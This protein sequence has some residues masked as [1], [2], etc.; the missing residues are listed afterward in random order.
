MTSA[1]PLQTSTVSPYSA[2][3]RRPEF[4]G[5]RSVRQTSRTT[6]AQRGETFSEAQRGEG[7]LTAESDA[8]DVEA[9]GS[10]VLVRG[11]G[12]YVM[13]RKIQRNGR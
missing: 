3:T 11:W 1:S 10:F 4:E 12:L 7:G 9:G 8:Q 6:F 5:A 13:A 2:S